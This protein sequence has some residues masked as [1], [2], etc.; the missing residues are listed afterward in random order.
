MPDTKFL[1]QVANYF[2]VH[3]F[4]YEI[5]GAR[6]SRLPYLSGVARMARTSEQR[7][8]EETSVEA[9]RYPA[10][11]GTEFVTIRAQNGALVAH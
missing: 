3:S 10:N 5:L 8:R 7:K 4:F 11:S 1:L 2:N 6:A 9:P